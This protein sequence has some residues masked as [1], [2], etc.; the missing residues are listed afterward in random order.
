MTLDTALHR[1]AFAEG[2]T[3]SAANMLIAKHR[4]DAEL[5]AIRDALNTPGHRPQGVN[6]IDKTA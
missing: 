1:L 6:A 2:R 5:K 3:H 4:N